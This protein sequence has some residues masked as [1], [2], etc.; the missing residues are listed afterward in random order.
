VTISRLRRGLIPFSSPGQDHTAH[1]LA[2][3]GLGQRG[4]VILLTALAAILGCTAIV[5]SQLSV[6]Q[7][8]LLLGM[9]GLVGLVAIIALERFIR[10]LP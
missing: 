3:L 7:S 2:K 1:R 5:V 9:L 4:T 6:G 8:Y 10:P